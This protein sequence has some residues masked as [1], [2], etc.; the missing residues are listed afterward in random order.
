MRKRKIVVFLCAVVFALLATSAATTATTLAVKILDESGSPVAARVYLTDEKGGN[1]FPSGT[2]VYKK[3]NWNV[4][5][6]H[7]IPVGGFFSIELPRNRRSK[8]G[9]VTAYSN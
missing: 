6:E 7:F 8:T 4:P 1:Y 2:V 3:M 9:Q 5:E